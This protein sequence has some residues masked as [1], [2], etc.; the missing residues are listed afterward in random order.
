LP[1]TC[2]VKVEWTWDPSRAVALFVDFKELVGRTLEG[3]NLTA[4]T[5]LTGSELESRDLFLFEIRSAL[6]STSSGSMFSRE[7]IQKFLNASTT[8]SSVVDL[9]KISLPDPGKNASLGALLE[10]TRRFPDD[11]FN[12][13][14]VLEEPE[15]LLE[16]MNLS[17]TAFASPDNLLRPDGPSDPF[18]SVHFNSTSKHE[19]WYERVQ[20]AS[21]NGT[22]PASEWNKT[23][24][25]EVDPPI[26]EILVRLL[27]HSP[28]NHADTNDT[29]AEEEWND[30]LVPSN[31]T[32]RGL[33]DAQKLLLL[34]GLTDWIRKG[35]G[36]LCLD[37]LE[38]DVYDVA[39]SLKSDL[40]QTRTYH[41]DALKH[42]LTQ[43]WGVR[44]LM[45]CDAWYGYFVEHALKDMKFFGD[46]HELTGRPSFGGRNK[47][48]DFVQVRLRAWLVIFLLLLSFLLADP[49]GPSS[50]SVP[51]Y[52]SLFFFFF[53]FLF[54]FLTF[55][56]S[57]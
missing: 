39:N 11:D 35:I 23:T 43:T 32:R 3:E 7:T 26:D 6:S 44:D 29:A 45:K 5:N 56:Q 33:T 40:S 30:P 13:T 38:H 55:F 50:L 37:G 19:E 48:Q 57:K 49:R 54:F 27:S 17:F 24:Y 4:H 25:T 14:R 46:W 8:N 51:F 31:S 22:R 21:S 28:V 52:L 2:G 53:F 16:E 18:P 42:L 10:D 36:A 12:R 9:A 47:P 41:W 20:I 34:K 15:R 1:A